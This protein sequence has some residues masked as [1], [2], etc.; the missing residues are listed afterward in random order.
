MKTQMQRFRFN[1]SI[2]QKAIDCHL[3]QYKNCCDAWIRFQSS[4][5]TKF[6]SFI[7]GS[8][9]G[10]TVEVVVS[11]LLIMKWMTRIAQEPISVQSS[12]HKISSVDVFFET[13][14]SD[15]IVPIN[16]I[17]CIKDRFAKHGWTGV[18]LALRSPS[19]DCVLDALRSKPLFTGQFGKL[20][21]EYLRIQQSTGK[22]YAKKLY[23]AEFNRFLS[24]HSVD[25][26][27]DINEKTVAGW[28]GS[29]ACSNNASRRRLS[30]LNQ[31]FGHLCSMA[32][33][34]HNPVIESILDRYS[35]SR[36]PF[37]PYIYTHDEIS[38]LLESSKKLRCNARFMLKP[39][40]LHMT[41]ALLYALGL[42]IGE[43][44]RLT[45]KDI[46]LHQKI[47][48]IR[49]SKF[50]KDRLLPFGSKLG[51]CLEVYLDLR[52]EYFKP[53]KKDDPL[54]ISHK[55]TVIRN[56]LIEQAFR[57]ILKDAGIAA[58]P[59]G[60]RRPRLH[61]LRHT[62]ALHRLLRWYEEDV[63]VQDK[64]PLLSTFMGHVN[65]YSTQVYLTITDSLLREASNRFYSQFGTGFDERKTS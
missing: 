18:V 10:G 49:D 45:I 22:H 12:V 60:Q 13:L 65:I 59:P 32:I 57:D 35:Y 37:K 48:F 26:I 31:F 44:L 9:A 55:C 6:L 4:N 8:K 20:A 7:A 58:P 40:V 30:A 43:A 54:L 33:V 28:I 3:V 5:I 23:L 19:P 41:I 62:F 17:R 16:P 46:D 15:S 56:R 51:N 61:D 29:M 21:E 42:R 64:L 34:R 11:E 38:R 63:N 25:C 27:N 47:L 39:Y 14:T 1:I 53:V 2:A 50:Y 36:G 52:R 24:K